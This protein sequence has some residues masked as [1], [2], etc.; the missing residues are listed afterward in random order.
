MTEITDESMVPQ[1]MRDVEKRNAYNVAYKKDNTLTVNVR[2][3]KKTEADLI[4]FMETVNNK[5]GLIKDLLRKYMAETGH[6]PKP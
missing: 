4:S 5:Q 1:D 2:L 6:T 3:N